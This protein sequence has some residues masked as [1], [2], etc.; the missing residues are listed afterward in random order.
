MHWQYAVYSHYARVS[1]GQENVLVLRRCTQCV[2]VGLGKVGL[3]HPAH[4]HPAGEYTVQ[5][6]TQTRT[7]ETVEKVGK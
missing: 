6:A 4:Q 3:S 2:E 5:G 1:L 7:V